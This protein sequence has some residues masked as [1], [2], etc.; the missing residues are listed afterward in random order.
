MT[1]TERVIFNNDHEIIKL[2]FLV[3]K[4]QWYEAQIYFFGYFSYSKPGKDPWRKHFVSSK[5]NQFQILKFINL[6]QK[7][8]FSQIGESLA[9]F[10]SF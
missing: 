4:G 6:E 8:W 1:H 2:H 7:L 5:K 3:N 10:Q 9:K